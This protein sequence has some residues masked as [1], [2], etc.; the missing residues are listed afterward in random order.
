MG[1]NHG[2]ILGKLVKKTVKYIKKMMRVITNI[3]DMGDGLGPPTKF[4]VITTI[5]VVF[6]NGSDGHFKTNLGFIGCFI[7]SFVSE[8]SVRED[9]KTKVS[10]FRD[11]VLT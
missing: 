8:K 1:C 4:F 11:I 10:R 5:Y 9:C 3:L 2:H 6:V 7:F